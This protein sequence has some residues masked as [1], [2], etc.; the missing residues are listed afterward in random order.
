KI[1]E[2]F[3]N[4]SKVDLRYN[5]IKNIEPLKNCKQLSEVFVDKDVDIRP[6]EN[7]KN[8]LKNADSYTKAKLLN[9]EIFK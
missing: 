4:L 5:N 9:K 2:N 8:Q 6:I 7:M 1:L 3:K